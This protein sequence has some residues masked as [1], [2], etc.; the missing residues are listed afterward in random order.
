MS[1]GHGSQRV[2]MKDQT[3]I[4]YQNDTMQFDRNF[5]HYTKNKNRKTEVMKI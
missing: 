2:K 4:A 5:P 1:R 3:S